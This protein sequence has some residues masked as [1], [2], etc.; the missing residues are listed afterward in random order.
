MGDPFL[1]SWGPGALPNPEA[2]PGDAAA[3]KRSGIACKLQQPPNLLN[4][5]C[6]VLKSQIPLDTPPF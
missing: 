4:A 1:S 3:T 2:T 6:S 5:Q